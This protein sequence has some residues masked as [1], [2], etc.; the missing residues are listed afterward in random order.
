MGF[1]NLELFDCQEYN[2]IVFILKLS[3]IPSVVAYFGFIYCSHRNTFQI[4]QA[5]L[6]D[7]KNI[8]KD[9]CLCIHLLLTVLLQ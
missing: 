9:C 6:V 2:H 3:F 4:G 7:M 5:P 8:S 1:L